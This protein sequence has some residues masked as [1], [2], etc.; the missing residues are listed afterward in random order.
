M[1]RVT[2]KTRDPVPASFRRTMKWV[3]LRSVHR[4][5]SVRVCFAVS[6]CF[7][8]VRRPNAVIHLIGRIS[9]IGASR[10]CSKVNC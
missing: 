1:S 2:E 6:G 4:L 5:I 9:K 3:V 8:G 7:V 10:A